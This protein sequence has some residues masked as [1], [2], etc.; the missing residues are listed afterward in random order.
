MT[1]WR[2]VY[3][4]GKIIVVQAFDSIEVLVLPLSDRFKRMIYLLNGSVFY[5]NGVFLYFTSEIDQEE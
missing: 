3:E 2:D 1:L 5:S 4:N